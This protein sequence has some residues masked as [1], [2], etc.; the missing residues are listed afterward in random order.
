MEISEKKPILG[1]LINN[2]WL[3]FAVVFLFLLAVNLGTLGNPPYWDEIIGIH[4]HALWLADNDFN[5][6]KLWTTEP[7][8][9]GGGSNS[10]SLSLLALFYALLYSILPHACI[11]LIAHTLT[12]MCMAGVFVLFFKVI[13]N[14]SVSPIVAFMWCA[15]ALCAPIVSGRCAAIYQEV[16]LLALSAIAIYFFSKRKIAACCA[17]IFLAFL[18]KQ[19]AILLVYALVAWMIFDFILRKFLNTENKP[20]KARNVLMVLSEAFVLSV[21]MPL[22]SSSWSEEGSVNFSIMIKKIMNHFFYF[23]H[24]E[25]S[26]LILIALTTAMAFISAS[27]RKKFLKN[28]FSIYLL[29]LIAGFWLSYA[30]LPT[31]LPRYSLF[32]IFPMCSFLAIALPKRI[33]LILATLFILWGCLNQNGCL[34]PPLPNNLRRSGACLE[35]SREFLKDL[36]ANKKICSTL[37]K[38]AFNTPIVAKWPFVQMLTMPRLGYVSKALP[39][40]YAAGIVP[41]YTSAKPLNKSTH[42][43]HETLYIYVPNDYESWDKFN[44]SLKPYPND[45]IIYAEASIPGEILIFKSEKEGTPK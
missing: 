10:Y 36:K 23:M 16:P 33:S 24:L 6:I 18:V 44:P 30:L 25:A 22:T 11:F 12:L 3:L 37:E 26:E 9:L 35:R 17:F 29:I 42:L 2:S 4:N 20:L 1:C 8:C 34:Y 43:P 21:A 31:P 13:K 7:T 32:V 14:S 41:G 45:I 19:T 15:A 40:I 27:Y 28:T 38:E 39:N 5:L